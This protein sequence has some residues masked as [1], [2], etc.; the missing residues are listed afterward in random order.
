MVTVSHLVKKELDKRDFIQ[1]GLSRD[2]ISVGNLAEELLPEL[3]SE[4]GKKVKLPAIIMAIRRYAENLNTK[5]FSKIPKGSNLSMISG[6][7]DIG[8]SKSLT[9]PHKIELLLKLP[10]FSKGDVMNIIQGSLEASIITNAKFEKK[11]LEILKGE[12]III[13]EKNLSSV[14][15]IFGK[16]FLHSPGVLF[17]A[18][19]EIAWNDINI[20]ELVSTTSELTFILD[21]K[22]AVRAYS[23][24]QNKLIA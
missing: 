17:A 6:L 3:E 10:D 19:K 18:M 24:L 11:V 20:F 8:V 21:K 15:L 2:L 23:L 13:A 9:L 7:I 22:D 1:E 14:S 5:K 4:L 12:H 16:E